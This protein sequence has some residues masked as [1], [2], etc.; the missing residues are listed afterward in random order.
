MWP[1]LA[2]TGLQTSRTEP[3]LHVHVVSRTGRLVPVSVPDTPTGTCTLLSSG[4]TAVHVY[5]GCTKR[6]KLQKQTETDLTGNL[7]GLQQPALC[8]TKCSSGKPRHA[9]PICAVVRK[10]HALLKFP[11]NRVDA[12]EQWAKRM[13]YARRA[14]ASYC[15]RLILSRRRTQASWR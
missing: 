7:V 8:S 9:A 1:I 4:P 5:Q 11:K 6:I 2:I 3:I 14:T 15:T 10:A 12:E 13:S